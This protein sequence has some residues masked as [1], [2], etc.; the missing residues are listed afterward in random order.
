MNRPDI[1]V[2]SHDLGRLSSSRGVV[3]A[4]DE[5]N[6]LGTCLAALNDT[7]MYDDPVDTGND[8]GSGTREQQDEGED[9]EAEPEDNIVNDPP[10]RLS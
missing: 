6:R 10:V 4:Q 5:I 8:W 2:W 1:T 3:Q 9:E 7:S